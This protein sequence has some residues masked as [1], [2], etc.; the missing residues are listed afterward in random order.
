[1]EC[2]IFRFRIEENKGR[3]SIIQFHPSYNYEDFVRGIQ[4]R[5]G[6]NDQ[7]KSEIVYESVNRI[8]GHMAQAALI[9]WEKAKRD[10]LQSLGENATK[11]KIV[12]K[13]KE[14]AD[15]FVLII[16][17]INRANLAAVLGE[18]IYALEYRG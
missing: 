1:M 7:N 6:K 9:K 12:N 15:K 2:I 4:V 8:L 18:L 3:W 14:E 17:E 16:D 11:N 5:T 13:A 10:A